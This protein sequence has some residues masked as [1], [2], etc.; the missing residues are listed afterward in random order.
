MKSYLIGSAVEGSEALQRAQQV[1]WSAN[2]K[3]HSDLSVFASHLHQHQRDQSV[4]PRDTG[5]ANG[6]RWQSTSK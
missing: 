6:F 5:Q 1:S 3:P 4:L 2:A